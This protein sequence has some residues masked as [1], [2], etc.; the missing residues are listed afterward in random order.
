MT[1]DEVLA[2]VQAGA[3]LGAKE[4]LFSLGDKPEALFPEH[5]EFL[6]RLGTGRRS[7]TCAPCA[8][9][10][11]RRVRRSCRT[12]IPGLMSERDLAALREVNVSMGIMLETHRPSGCSARATRT[13]RAR[14]GARRAGSGPS[15]LRGQA[16]HPLHHRHP[17]R[18]RRDAARARGRARSPSATLHE[19]YGHIQEVIVQNFRAKPTHPDARTRRSRRSTICCGRSRWRGSCSAPT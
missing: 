10:M 13:T 17:D 9:R 4:A 14:Q 1:P 8:A 19:R 5:R 16:R 7:T 15:R 12:P 2:L 6:R 11:L 18:D 3:R